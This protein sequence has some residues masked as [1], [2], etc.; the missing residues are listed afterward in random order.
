MLRVEGE[1]ECH[2][3]ATVKVLEEFKGSVKAGDVFDVPS[4]GCGDCT[5]PF[6]PEQEYLMYAGKKRS[7]VYYCSR[8]RELEKG[9]DTDDAEIL[10]LRTGKLPPMPLALQRESV[11]CV[12]CDIYDVAAR[13]AP[14]RG[15]PGSCA[16]FDWEPQAEEKMK[17]G[18]PFFTRAEASDDAHHVMVGM[19]KDGKAFELTQTPHLSVP[20]RCTQRVELRWCSRVEVKSPGEGMYPLFRCIEPGPAQLQCDEAPTRKAAWMPAE[21]FEATR[22]D[23]SSPGAPTCSLQGPGRPLSG[24]IMT[25]PFL[26]C[27]PSSGVGGDTEHRCRVAPELQ[28]FDPRA[29]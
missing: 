9:A 23:W 8:T 11:T 3:S 29:P 14:G 18:Q 27:R 15:S 21:V 1:D 28:Q 20:E 25:G 6:E 5:I 7:D 4:G 17:A 10:W 22:C 13:V 16:D 19:T 12:P 26:L 2:R 24:K